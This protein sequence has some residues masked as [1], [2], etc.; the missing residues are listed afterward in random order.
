[1]RVSRRRVLG[2]MGLGALKMAGCHADNAQGIA[3]SG[4][5]AAHA[6]VIGIRAVDPG[7]YDG[8]NEPLSF[9]ELDAVAF[10]DHLKKKVGIADVTTILGTDVRLERIRREIVAMGTRTKPGELAC[11]FYS[12]HGGQ[13]VTHDPGELDGF[14]QS[15]C[16]YDGQ[17][18]DNERYWLLQDYA[19]GARVLV[20][21]D[22]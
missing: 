12:G 3:K 21:A 19:P 20:I 16:L 8:W 10:S 15:W 5:L 7:E 9:S 4:P 6:L 13:V 14:D 18:L 11:I 2:M 17:F 1:M 22:C